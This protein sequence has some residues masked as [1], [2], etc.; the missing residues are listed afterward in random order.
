MIARGNLTQSKMCASL[1]I[2]CRL[3]KTPTSWQTSIRQHGGQLQVHGLH[4]P[5]T[6]LRVLLRMRC[7]VTP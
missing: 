2:Q 6:H 5:R 3:G 4:G 1:P 7:E